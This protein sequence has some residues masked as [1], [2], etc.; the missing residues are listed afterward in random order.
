MLYYIIILINS[1]YQFN[2]FLKNDQIKAQMNLY[3]PQDKK[4]PTQ[5]QMRRVAPRMG[6]TKQIRKQN[7]RSGIETRLL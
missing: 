4:H 2:H 5:K 3:S 1:Q 7:K 6:I